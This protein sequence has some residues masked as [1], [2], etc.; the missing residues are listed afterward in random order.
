MY[1][2]VYRDIYI[3]LNPSW[4]WDVRAILVVCSDRLSHTWL[5]QYDLAD[6][7]EAMQG[8]RGRSV[9]YCSRH[10]RDAAMDDG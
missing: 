1:L 3:A 4:G 8:V 6:I 2:E 7:E 10:T 9:Q 5:G